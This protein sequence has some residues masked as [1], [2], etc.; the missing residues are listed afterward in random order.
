[1]ENEGRT[2]FEM[3]LELREAFRKKDPE[4]ASVPLSRL[5]LHMFDYID[6]E[7]KTVDG[8]TVWLTWG[9][10]N[11]EGEDVEGDDIEQLCARASII[12]YNAMLDIE[13]LAES[14]VIDKDENETEA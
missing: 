11:F 3:L 1:M 4:E 5:I 12:A 14:Y 9:G 8:F 13:E 10:A 7:R 2:T 6:F